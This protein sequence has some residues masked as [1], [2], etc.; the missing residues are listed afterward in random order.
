M[1]DDY[2]EGQAMVNGMPINGDLGFR[3]TCN[4]P[5]FTDWIK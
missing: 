1:E 4:Q 3:Y 5:V 2:L